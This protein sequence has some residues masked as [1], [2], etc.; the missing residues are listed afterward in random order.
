M[1]LE[2]TTKDTNV[3]VKILAQ[4]DNQVV[5]LQFKSAAHQDQS[6]VR[7]ELRKI[8]GTV[9][10][11]LNFLQ[12]SAK[13][14]G[15]KLKLEETWTSNN[16]FLFGKVPVVKRHMEGLVLKGLSRISTCMKDELP[17]LSAAMSNTATQCLP[18]RKDTTTQFSQWWLAAS[19][20]LPCVRTIFITTP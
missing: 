3:S 18:S 8:K 9:E 11:I 4:G 1:A 13:A 6:E 20:R 14:M 2:E 10:R 15:L 5:S 7:Q 17:S 16:I 12:Q 19:Q